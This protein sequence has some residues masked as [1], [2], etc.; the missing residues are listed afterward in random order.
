MNKR[1]TIIE[2][3]EDLIKRKQLNPGDK[4]PSEYSLSKKFLVNTKTANLAINT[5]VSRGIL[6]R[7]SGAAGTIVAETSIYPKGII[8]YLGSIGQY[9]NFWGQL[10]KGAQKA[11][12]VRGYALHYI[13]HAPHN[14]KS[15][16]PDLISF[17]IKGLLTS[18]YGFI[19]D[20]LP[21]PVIHVDHQAP[22]KIPLNFVTNDNLKAGSIITRHLI[23]SNHRDIV[24]LSEVCNANE[25]A[26]EER[27][28]GFI[29][30][31][32]SIGIADATDRIFIDDSNCATVF[33]EI[34]RKFPNSTAIVFDSDNAAIKMTQF[35]LKHG[36]RIPEDIS[37]VGFGAFTKAM[38]TMKIT[39][40]EQFPEDTGYF[41]CQALIEIIEN[42]RK[43]PITEKLPVEIFYGDSVMPLK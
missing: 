39:S 34:K 2:Y 9:Y 36:I 8:T 41:A 18:S 25:P 33:K 32:E 22:M 27:K 37:I 5:M 1:E 6:K 10:V 28:N 23:E 31:L 14:L 12:F 26:I 3:I 21:F 7:L 4:I 30:E 43:V 17:G 40:I 35:C 13:E 15:L 11:A 19:D 24:F 20:A 42:K 16:W 29:H 38:P